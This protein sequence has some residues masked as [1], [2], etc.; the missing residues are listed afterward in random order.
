MAFLKNL[1]K[2]EKKLEPKNLSDLISHLK[3]TIETDEKIAI[4]EW[5]HN[6]TCFKATQGKQ[7]LLE[8]RRSMSYKNSYVIKC[9]GHSYEICYGEK[10]FDAAKSLFELCKSK[11]HEEYQNMEKQS[12]I[13][14]QMKIA[15]L[16]E[17]IRS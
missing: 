2:K 16:I 14:K 11:R 4:S 7:E 13:R 1:F 3:H 6:E 9:L 10:E 5:G 8:I 15:T 17:R 12:E